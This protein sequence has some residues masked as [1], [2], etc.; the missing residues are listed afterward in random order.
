MNFSD[1]ALKGELPWQPPAGKLEFR[2]E[3]SAPG[4]SVMVPA[5]GPVVTRFKGDVPGSVLVLHIIAMF[6]GMLLST[7]AGLEFLSPAGNLRKLTLWTIAFLA[8]GGAILGPVVQKYAFNAYW[9][10]WPFGTDLTDNKTAVAL[11]AW[12]GAYVALKRSMRPQ[13][14]AA[15]AAVLTLAVFMIPHSLLG[16]ELDYKKMDT[17]A[18]ALTIEAP[19]PRVVSGAQDP[20]R[21]AHFTASSHILRMSGRSHTSGRSRGRSRTRAPCRTGRPR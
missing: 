13:V 15:V 4:Q 11:A 7:R 21:I 16:S 19:G 10:G 6:G 14:W 20:M 5:A 12:L 18:A 8:V 3:L 17:P 1:G 9:T 2:L